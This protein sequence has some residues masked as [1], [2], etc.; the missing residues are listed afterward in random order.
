MGHA[1]EVDADF[2]TRSLDACADAAL[3]R[4]RS[5]GASHADVRV[6]STRTS[7]LAL[8]DAHLEGA[9]DDRT[10]GLA[11]RVVHD[12]CWGFASGYQV[13]PDA[14]AAL[15]SRAVALAQVSRPLTTQRIELVPEPVHAGQWVSSYEIDPFDVSEQ[16]R[17]DLLAERSAR[18]LRHDAVQFT[19]AKALSVK[20]QVFYADLSGTRTTQQRVRVECDIDAVSVDEVS[21]G[22]QSMRTVAPP[23]GRGWEY[24]LG[25]AKTVGGSRAWD[26]DDELDRLPDLL[27]QKVRAPSVDPGR[28][29]LVIDPTNL[30]LTIHESVGH[31]TELDRVLGYEANYA[32][33]SFATLDKLGSLAYGSPLMHVVADREAE[34]GLSTVRWDDEGVAAGH[35]DLIRDGALVGYQLDRAMA[36]ELGVQRSNGCAYADSASHTAIQRM[37]N[38]SLQPSPGGPDTDALIAGVE[39]GI[40]VVGDNSWSIDMQR[41]NFQFTAQRFFR[42]KAGR[43]EGQLK[44]VVYQ[45]TTTDFWGSLV[46]TGGEQTYLMGGAFNCGKGQPGQAAA[47][48]HGAPASVFE[49][50]NVLNGVE[51]SGR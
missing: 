21:G 15:A 14:A 17:A 40:Y 28:Y 20:E 31:T 34:H 18:L 4:A 10:T 37:P 7:Y 46:A 32:G 23:S 27:A 45:A 6:V 25:T 33:T 24:V 41:F 2:L 51:E 44:D 16:A 43:L 49:N 1:R 36:A 9:V 5:L 50:V 11:V 3:A 19:S 47:V 39:D 22:F 42:I 30:W 35:W 13:T 8:R 48:S 29:T 12:G 38:V 26:W